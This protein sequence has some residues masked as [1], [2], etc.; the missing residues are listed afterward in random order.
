GGIVTPGE[1]DAAAIEAEDAAIGDG[2]AM[3][4]GS[5]IGEHLRGAAEGRLEVDVPIGPGGTGQEPIE[6][7]EIASD[8]GRKSERAGGEGSTQA[9]AE[10]SAKAARQSLDPEK[11]RGL[12]QTN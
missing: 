12:A 5:Q 11:K 1:G 2:D 10:Q 7:R 4:V 6:R 9:V 3:G 8:G